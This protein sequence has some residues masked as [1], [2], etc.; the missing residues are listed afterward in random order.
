MAVLSQN[1]KFNKLKI[2]KP[3]LLVGSAPHID[4]YLTPERLM[5]LKLDKYFTICTGKAIYALD[6][7]NIST[8]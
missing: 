4:E 1:K 2:D 3:V 7:V 6:H 8:C 5:Y